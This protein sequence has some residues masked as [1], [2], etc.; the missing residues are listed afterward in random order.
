MA[1]L[2]NKNILDALR[3]KPHIYMKVLVQNYH[4]ASAKTYD[5]F[6]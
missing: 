3:R 6:V 4:M 5:I 1:L 2:G